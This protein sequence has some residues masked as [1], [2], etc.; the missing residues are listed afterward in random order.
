M[1]IPTLSVLSCDSDITVW[2]LCSEGEVGRSERQTVLWLWLCR[3][4]CQL[5]FRPQR[6]RHTHRQK[7]QPAR[8]PTVM[9]TRKDSYAFSTHFF[10]LCSRSLGCTT[11][12]NS[13]LKSKCLVSGSWLYSYNLNMKHISTRKKASISHACF[14]VMFCFRLNAKQSTIL[15]CQNFWSNKNKL[16]LMIGILFGH[17]LGKLLESTTFSWWR[18]TF[19]HSSSCRI[20]YSKSPDWHLHQLRQVLQ[21]RAINFICRSKRHL[22]PTRKSG[23][24]KGQGINKVIR[25]HPLGIMKVCTK[26]HLNPSDNWGYISVWTKEVDW[27]TS[28]S[29]G[30]M[31]PSI[32]ENVNKTVKIPIW[33]AE[34]RNSDCLFWRSKKTDWYLSRY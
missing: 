13:L 12:R 21:I 34:M 32:T 15:A 16:H 5:P 2:W 1:A 25:I 27:P 3:P 26:W 33:A 24:G 20:K 19:Q 11:S 29:V 10:L 7:G 14:Y 28:S 9:E 22:R 8:C 6:C 31:S 4:R 23:V 30:T 18:S 17:V